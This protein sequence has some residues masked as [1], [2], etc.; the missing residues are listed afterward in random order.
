LLKIQIEDTSS[1][2]SQY[3]YDFLKRKHRFQEKLLKNIRLLASMKEEVILSSYH[4]LT[5][6]YILIFQIKSYSEEFIQKSQLS[7]SG[8]VV[9]DCFWDEL[10]LKIEM[11]TE[12]L[13]S[14]SELVI[15]FSYSFI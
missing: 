9:I 7:G 5:W 3:D 14:L 6:N 15:F 8:S 13:S 11:T 4:F 12:K 1:S 10:I 2:S